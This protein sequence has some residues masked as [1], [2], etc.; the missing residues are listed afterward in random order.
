MSR[1]LVKHVRVNSASGCSRL[2]WLTLPVTPNGYSETSKRRIG[3]VSLLRWHG[4]S[5]K[6][7]NMTC[8]YIFLQTVLCVLKRS[9]SYR[10]ISYPHRLCP[11]N[12]LAEVYQCSLQGYV[13][14]LCKY[15]C[16]NIR[17][18]IWTFIYACLHSQERII[19][20]N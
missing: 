13:Y 2:N 17:V 7:R 8:I 16:L 15:A 12:S 11:F 3:R 1:K 19:P 20:C 10:R 14:F 5:N 9:W 6:I 18:H 4:N